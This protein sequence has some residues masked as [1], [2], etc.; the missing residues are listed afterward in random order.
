MATG[1]V[2]IVA[3]FGRTAAAAA[4]ISRCA[5]AAAGVAAVQPLIRV[6]GRGWYFTALAVVTGGVGSVVV[7]MIRKWGAKWRHE[8]EAKTTRACGREDGG[9]AGLIDLARLPAGSREKSLSKDVAGA[10]STT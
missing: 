7:W 4:S 1:F 3:K 9:E 10:T 2:K 8:R 5:L 6:L